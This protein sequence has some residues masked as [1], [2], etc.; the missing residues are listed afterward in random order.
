MKK[1]KAILIGDIDRAKYHPIH[2]FSELIQT[3][4]PLWEVDVSTNYDDFHIENL[5]KYDAFIVMIDQ[6]IPL[7]DEQT[8]GII[9]SIFHGKKM[10]CIHQG[11]SLQAR[12]ELSILLRA[13]FTHHPEQTILTYLHVDPIHPIMKDIPQFSLLEEPYMF[14]LD[15]I[16]GVKPFLEYQY[17]D[18]FYPAGWAHRYGLG[19]ICYLAIGHHVEAFT[20]PAVQSIIK[21]SMDWLI[22]SE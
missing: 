18:S 21:N 13:R 16:E 15:T 8:F 7:S 14:I 10:L 2:G 4:L 5:S 6:W 1:N 11:I 9:Q 22:S 3:I 19:K 12:G 20:H 17:L